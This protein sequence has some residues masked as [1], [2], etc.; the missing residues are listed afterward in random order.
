[1]GEQPFWKITRVLKPMSH[2]PTFAEGDHPI[3]LAGGTKGP[4]LEKKTKKD[5][6]PFEPRSCPHGRQRR[7]AKPAAEIL[8]LSKRDMTLNF[9]NA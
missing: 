9:I 1:M 5:G 6:A 3:S 8:R 4:Q 2:A 7:L